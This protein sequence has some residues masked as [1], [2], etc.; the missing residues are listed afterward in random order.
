MTVLLR[1][2]VVSFFLFIARA[3]SATVPVSA[4]FLPEQQVLPQLDALQQKAAA[5]QKLLLLVLGAQWCHDSKAVQQHFTEPALAAALAKRYDIVYVDVGYLEFGQA[6]TQRYQLPLYYGT[7]TLM[8]IAPDS[9]QLLNKSD[10]MHWTSAANF[11]AA[12]YKAYFIDTDFKQQFAQQQQ[13]LAGIKPAVVQQISAFEQQQA[14][15]LAQDYA[16]LGPMLRAYKE[17]GRAAGAEFNQA[18]NKVKAFRTQI[19]PQV[20]E[21]QQQAKNLAA[22]EALQ[23]P[24]TE[25]FHFSKD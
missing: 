21:L 9:G 12:A 20:T 2:A 7:P 13:Q 15:T 5:E 3:E 14:A 22:G 19:L 18:W 10:L 8:V 16:H 17:S 24:P 6:I 25:V 1:T 4:Q 11:D 23:L